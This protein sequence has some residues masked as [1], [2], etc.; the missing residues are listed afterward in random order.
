[1]ALV[2][3]SVA[4]GGAINDTAF[5]QAVGV[6]FERA[7]EL[8]KVALH[9]VVVDN[10]DIVYVRTDRGVARLFDDRLAIDQSFRP[11]AGKLARD[12][13]LH[14]GE[15]FYLFEDSW[16][17][18]AG[19]GTPFGS[20][21]KDVYRRIAV[22][23]DGAVLLASATHLGLVRAGKLTT[24]PFAVGRP[25]ERLYAWGTEFFVLTAEA[26]YRV[27]EGKIEVFHRGQ[28][29]TAL[30]FRPNEVV[31]G[32]RHGF[33]TLEAATGRPTLPMQTQLPCPEITCLAATPAG[34]WA[35]TTRGVFWQLG[36]GRFRYYAS[37]RWLGDD[38]VL[39]LQVDRHGDVYV[40]TRQGLN[41]IEFRP[42]TLAQKAA[43]YEEKIR[44][45]HIR[46]GFCSELRLLRPGDVRS[47]EMIDTDNDGS[48]S[49]L[50]L[51]SQA[52][53]YAVTGEAEA[54][55]NAW[56]TFTALERLQAING[57]FG[58][59]ARTF[60]RAGFKFSD[61]DRWHVAPDPNWE[62][63][64]HTSSDE[65]ALHTFAYAVLLE[66]AVRT[67]DERARIANAYDRILTH[68]VRNNLYLIDVDGQ[69]T[70]WGRWHPDYVNQYPPT[71]VDRRLNSAEIV[72]FLQFGHHL[73]PKDAY[74]DKAF[75]LMDR[76][77]YLANITN[78]MSRVRFTPGFVFRGNDMGNEWNHSDDQL[79]FYNYWTLYRYAFNDH[80][81]RL[82]AGA[83]K[84]HWDIE[85]IERNPA[86]N[87]IYASTGA[88]AFDLEGAL[89]T[90][91]NY[92]MDL[93]GW[94]VRNSHRLDL[95]FLPANFR[96]QQTEQLL[97]PDE[98]PVMRW[99]G[100][101][102]VLDGGNDGQTELAGDEF[103]LPYWMGRYLKIIQ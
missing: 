100:N 27:K 66:A 33:Y 86:W 92:P 45:R 1:M 70:L 8:E 56:E 54:R 2:L 35:G 88:S 53:R 68:I 44:R 74:R 18:N 55:A 28:D 4:V 42:L 61:P 39:D 16:L 34:L 21:P 22:A 87:F 59:P 76:H 79:A 85:R 30:A 83:V 46:Y 17:S 84:D 65:I 31:V 37:K 40:L 49:S 13:T 91:Q 47:A 48:W 11:L 19:G 57:L 75:E 90:L 3:A 72:A 71:I 52:F 60:E 98:R 99:N 38:R 96:Q 73:T 7:A 93:I 25:D 62:W 64:A 78:S 69:P 102:F 20:L 6:E 51:A 10:D 15:L 94:T 95:S 41:K 82:Y 26:V 63:K 32:T 24:L 29:L 9:Q 50:Y 43:Y 101:P 23:D 36:P 81:R 80:L 5:R 58:F 77:G 12:L 97:P 103:L 14:L 89:W 67:P